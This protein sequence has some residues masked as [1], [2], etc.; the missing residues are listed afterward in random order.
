MNPKTAKNYALH[1]AGQHWEVPEV[2]LTELPDG[3]SGVSFAEIG[4]M[5]RAVANRV[6][7]SPDRLT[8]EEFEFLCDVADVPFSEVARALD[9]NR[10]TLTKWRESNKPMQL[11]RSGFV[12]RWFWF[13]LFGDALGEVAIPLRSVEDDA[14]F[15]LRLMELAVD[16]GAASL[17]TRQGEKP[18]LPPVLPEATST[19]VVID[20]DFSRLARK[21][22]NTRIRGVDRRKRRADLRGQGNLA[23]WE[24][25]A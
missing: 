17:I 22:K 9:L 23:P 10:S 25:S 20:M 16:E 14:E 2:Q 1:V 24:I 3:G 6:C 18:S 8:G 11:V 12:K 4:R 7:G 21:A 15:L 19:G 5:M 13:E